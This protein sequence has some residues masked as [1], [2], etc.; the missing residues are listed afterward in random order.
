[1]EFLFTRVPQPGNNDGTSGT[2][3]VIY[4]NEWGS[5][6]DAGFGQEE[7]TVACR[8]FGFQYVYITFYRQTTGISVIKLN[9]NQA[10]QN[11]LVSIPMT[12]V[13]ARYE[14]SI[15]FRLLTLVFIYSSNLVLA[16][17]HLRIHK[18]HKAHKALTAD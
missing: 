7:A 5:V 14:F 8:Q 3:E 11:V 9:D 15:K 13:P 6:C 10:L 1:M 4:Q 16:G 2:I 12:H 17:A 18:A